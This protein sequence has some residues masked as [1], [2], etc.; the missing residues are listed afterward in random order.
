MN[1][2]IKSTLMLLHDAG[3]TSININFNGLTANQ[4]SSFVTFI[5]AL[6]YKVAAK[7]YTISIT[8]PASD[9]GVHITLTRLTLTLPIS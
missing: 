3:A 7:K 5:K 6:Y 9:K 2:L 4:H 8:I 1:S